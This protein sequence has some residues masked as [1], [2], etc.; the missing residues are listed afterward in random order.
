[1]KDWRRRNSWVMEKS[2][3]YHFMPGKRTARAEVD[4]PKDERMASLMMETGSPPRHIAMEHHQLSALTNTVTRR[5]E[6]TKPIYLLDS[7]HR[8]TAR[9]GFA[10]SVRT[11]KFSVGLNAIQPCW[12][13]KVSKSAERRGH[14]RGNSNRRG[15][16]KKNERNITRTSRFPFF[17]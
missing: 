9:T 12:R 11:V 4:S 17:M 13:A 16:R 15:K 8:H 14:S 6:P 7:V 2:I 5:A 3:K 1:M 10:S